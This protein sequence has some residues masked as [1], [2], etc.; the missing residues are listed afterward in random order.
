MTE[1][2]DIME[3]FDTLGVEA[4]R[5]T[6]INEINHTMGHHGMEVWI[7]FFFLRWC[8]CL[9]SGFV[10]CTRISFATLP[11]RLCL[12]TPPRPL[13]FARETA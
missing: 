4:A 7:S 3:V 12:L 11:L 8:G 2:N 10:D 13:C 6:I 9:L 1:S 5:S